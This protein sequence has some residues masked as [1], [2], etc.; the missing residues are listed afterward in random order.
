M[1]NQPVRVRIIAENTLEWERTKDLRALGESFAAYLG[2]PVEFIWARP[3]V[4]A[5]AR[6][7]AAPRQ[8]PPRR[9]CSTCTRGSVS[10]GV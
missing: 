4:A 8:K 1:T 9:N 2:E 7:A 6:D 5:L 3:E 10:N